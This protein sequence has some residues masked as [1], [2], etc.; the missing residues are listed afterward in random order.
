MTVIYGRYFAIFE[1][2]PEVRR[3]LFLHL[4]QR[5]FEAEGL[6]TIKYQEKVACS[7]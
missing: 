6:A 1:V 7:C 2:Q 4:C 5:K 3:G